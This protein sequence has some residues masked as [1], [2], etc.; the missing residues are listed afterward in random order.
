[1]K[2][3]HERGRKKGEVG[4]GAEMRIKANLRGER[5]RAGGGGFSRAGH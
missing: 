3:R 1:M 5:V 4:Q 2:S